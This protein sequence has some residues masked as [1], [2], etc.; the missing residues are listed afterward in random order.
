MRDAIDLIALIIVDRASTFAV[1]K[2]KDRVSFKKKE[3]DGR[4]EE[5]K[6]KEKT[7]YA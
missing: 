5:G 1:K 2:S 6:K 7:N 3:N 4:I